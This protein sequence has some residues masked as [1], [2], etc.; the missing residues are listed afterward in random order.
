MQKMQKI[1][2][3]FTAAILLVGLYVP[4]QAAVSPKVVQAVKAMGSKAVKIASGLPA[5]VGKA[6]DAVSGWLWRN[7]GV[8]ATGTVLTTFALQPKPFV[9]A[10]SNV[11]TATAEKV[12][13]TV[14]PKVGN[15]AVSTGFRSDYAVLLGLFGLGVFFLIFKDRWKIR[16][17]LWVP[18]LIFLFVFFV[19]CCCGVAVR[20]DS[21]EVIG[22][23]FEGMTKA[24][25]EAEA[26][27]AVSPGF[28]KMLFNLLLL[29]LLLIPWAG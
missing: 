5:T 18:I 15:I 20:A 3:M 26:N 23:A 29:F 24:F 27:S 22:Q 4:A 1:M 13:E 21:G 17:Q 6:G 12:V 19:I 14:V 10:A 25:S 11:T 9:E 7:K 16:R 28:L 8:V 2:L